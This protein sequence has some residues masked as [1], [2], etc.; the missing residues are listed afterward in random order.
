MFDLYMQEQQFDPRVRARLIVSLLAATAV[1]TG[2]MALMWTAQQF[3]IGQ[4]RAPSSR[5]EVMLTLSTDPPPPPA[6]P[7]RHEG[8]AADTNDSAPSSAPKAKRAEPELDELPTDDFAPATGKA[9]PQGETGVPDGGGGGTPGLKGGGGTPCLGPMCGPTPTP[10]GLPTTPRAPAIVRKPLSS[11]RAHS[12]FTPDPDRKALA[13]TTTGMTSRRSGKVSVGFCIEASGKVTSTS[14]KR[15]F[16][17]DPSVDK[18]CLA[19][20]KR[21][22]FR[23]A[24]VAGQARRT[25]S[26][27]TFDLRFD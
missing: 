3:S 16:G 7:P 13:K 22:R 2:A 23:P 11:L 18:L 9:K 26:E 24:K 20:V 10:I 1:T 19:A 8:A 27:V 15:K 14:L 25:C 12:I 21:W 17:G 5:A 4:V 6:P